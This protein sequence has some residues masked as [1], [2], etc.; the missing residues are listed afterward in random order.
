M[1]L[2]KGSTIYI[3]PVEALIIER[4]A[5]NEVL[6]V[7]SRLLRAMGFSRG[8]SETRAPRAARGGV[9]RHAAVALPLYRGRRR[10]RERLGRAFRCVV[11]PGH[12]PGHTCLYEPDSRT[13]LAGDVF[14]PVIQFFSDQENP[15]RGQFA[16]FS[17]LDLLGAARVLP[18]H[19]DMLTGTTEMAA[20][21]NAHHMARSMSNRRSVDGFVDGC[22]SDGGLC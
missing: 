5:S 20:Q 16:S 15:L 17:R 14:S 2:R 19:R 6:P 4:I 13:L 11:T 18:G 1:I 12:S 3:N 21:L 9:H 22:L 7:L 8:R 10:H